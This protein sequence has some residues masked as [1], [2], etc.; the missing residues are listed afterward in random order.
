VN[1][2]RTNG[3]SVKQLANKMAKPK[4]QLLAEIH[5]DLEAGPGF[6]PDMSDVAPGASEP[7]PRPASRAKGGKIIRHL[8]D[9]YIEAMI[10]FETCGEFWDSEVKG[11]RLRIGARKAAWAFF[12]QRRDHGRRTHTFETL[13][14][15][16]TMKCFDAR[17]AA[18]V[19][20]GDVVSGTVAPPKSKQKKFADAFTEYVEY[21]ERK[22]AEEGKPA[23]WARNV[24]QLGKQLILPRWCTWSLLDM[25]RDT[26]R[27]AIKQWHLEVKTENGPSSA[28]HSARIIRAIYLQQA[29]TNDSLSTE[30]TGQGQARLRL[31]RLPR[32]ACQVAHA[33]PDPASVSLD[34]AIDRGQA[35][36]ARPD[37][38]G[39]PRRADPNADHRGQQ[40]RK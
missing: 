19:V 17:Q 24:K 13:G 33:S 21:L 16:P 4:R 18:R 2:E 14:Y 29:K 39:Q 8:E 22:A 34:H 9:H 27:E 11:L 40:G 3:D 36:R 5:R 6:V 7:K 26:G 31:A 38:M 37:T 1:K 10:D 23:R 25:S 35:R 15:F 12:S 20:S 28:N 30:T 32:V